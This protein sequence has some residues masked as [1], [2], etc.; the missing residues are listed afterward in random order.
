MMNKLIV[1]MI[2]LFA[3]TTLTTVVSIQ[4]S[5]GAAVLF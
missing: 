3:Q 4:K 1:L 5:Y 2:M